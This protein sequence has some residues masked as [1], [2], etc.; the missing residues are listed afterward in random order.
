MAR[1]RSPGYPNVNLG[2][3]I[4]M[5]GKIHGPNR[6]NPIDREAAVQDM[7]YSGVT[8]ASGKM[9]SN[10]LHYGL[11]EKAGKGSVRVSELAVDI[12][13]PDNV[14]RKRAALHAAAFTPELFDQIREKFPHGAP[15]ENAIK[16]Y[17]TRSGF[18][19]V[20]IAPAVSSFLE[21][22][23]ILQQEN[24][25][26]SYEGEAASVV[27]SPPMSKQAEGV[28]MS[29]PRK[30]VGERPTPDASVARGLNVQIGA[31]SGERTVFVEEGEPG[32][33]L[34]LVASGEITDYLLEA[35]EDYVRRQRKRLTK[36]DAD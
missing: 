15:S 29:T 22:C 5:V 12:L 33:H 23:N 6:T 14:E 34:R 20:A 32:Q 8:G 24:A 17:L 36:A 26:E 2:E 11:L 7:G 18:S 19:D 9:L 16:S 3:A 31:T 10:L 4:E 25:Y 30:G 27:D 1:I 13:H 28:M 21:T 35:L